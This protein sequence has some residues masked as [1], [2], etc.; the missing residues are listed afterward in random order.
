MRVKPPRALVVKSARTLLATHFVRIGQN[1]IF[2]FLVSTLLGSQR[3]GNRKSGG[4]WSAGTSRG[5]TVHRAA[6]RGASRQRAPGPRE[7]RLAESV[8]YVWWN[9][10]WYTRERIRGPNKLRSQYSLLRTRERL[11]N[12]VLPRLPVMLGLHTGNLIML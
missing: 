5:A 1:T 10:R 2:W 6:G 11:E 9:H 4:S 12:G 3:P 7:A 8:H